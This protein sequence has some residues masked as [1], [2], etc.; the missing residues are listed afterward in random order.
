V[1]T[2]SLIRALG[3][4]AI[5]A[6]GAWFTLDDERF[7]YVCLIVIGGVALKTLSAW[8]RERS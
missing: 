7:R 3:L 2:T 5:L 1:T 8:G 4:Y 6:A